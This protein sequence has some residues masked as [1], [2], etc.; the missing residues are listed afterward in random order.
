MKVVLKSGGGAASFEDYIVKLPAGATVF[1]EGDV[2]TEMYVIQSGT[3]DIVKRVKDEAKSLS[4]LEKG[5]FFG[6]MSILED[7]PRTSSSAP[8]RATRS[9]ASSPTGASRSST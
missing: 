9:T 3:I 8:A 6:E 1:T 5:D 2:G 7:V 4:V